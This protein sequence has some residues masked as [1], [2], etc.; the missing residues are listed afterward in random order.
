MK[1]QTVALEILA[2]VV[3]VG[4]LG[5]AASESPRP[6]PPELPP[7]VDAAFYRTGPTME[8]PPQLRERNWGG[9]SCVHA[10]TVML[11]RWQKLF[12]VAEKWRRTYSGGE[13]SSRL[14]ER[15]EAA[16]LRYAYTL[17]GDEAFLE[18]CI[19][20]RR[21]AGIFYKPSHAINL[22]GLDKNYAYL[23]DNN[24]PNRPEQQGYERVPRAEF[25]RRWKQDYGGFAWTVV[26]FPPP[27]LPAPPEDP[28][29]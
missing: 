1:S 15:M 11:L 10:S 26:Y 19:Q 7:L 24:Y 27:M 16:G 17:D 5:P 21:G 13:Y 3:A 8:L 6:G 14:I 29:T 18:W 25:M 2:C 23:L 20:T 28:P 22:V 9:G 12:D 4:L